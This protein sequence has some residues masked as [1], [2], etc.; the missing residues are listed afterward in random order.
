MPNAW[1]R[2]S[3]EIRARLRATIRAQI[4]AGGYACEACGRLIPPGSP[5][6]ADHRVPIYWLAESGMSITDPTNLRGLHVACNRRLGQALATM[7]KRRRSGR[8]PKRLPR[9]QRPVLIRCEVC[10]EKT[11][12]SP[13]E[14]C[15]ALLGEGGEVDEK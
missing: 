11:P 8:A 13:C 12:T 9:S 5:F 10:R 14:L 2:V 1:N 6:D 15:T 7:S 4:D 3:P